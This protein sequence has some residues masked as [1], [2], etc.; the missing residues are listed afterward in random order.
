MFNQTIVIGNLTRAIELKYMPSGA[1]I[2]RGAIATSHKYKTQDGSQKEEVCFLDFKVF[3]KPAEIIN[4]YV[5]KGSKVMLIGRLVFEQWTDK[6]GGNRSRHTLRVEEFK[7]LDQNNQQPDK[8]NNQDYQYHD[9][10]YPDI[11]CDVIPPI[12]EKQ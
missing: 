8:G 12:Q 3:G 2:A 7:F 11:D 4:Q 5:K 6:D 10:P 1:A 9:F